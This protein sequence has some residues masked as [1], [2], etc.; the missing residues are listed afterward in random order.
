[1]TVAT[2]MSEPC[3]S[4][5]PTPTSASPCIFDG[6]DADII[7]RAPLHP[8]SNEFK[9][10][11]VHKLILSIASAVFRDMFSIPQPPH[12]ASSDATLDV[13]QLTEFANVLE[14]FLK[15]IYPV[16][17]PVIDNLRLL[18]DLFQLADKYVANGVT[19][20]LKQFLV[21]PSFLK[22]D[23]IG[24]Y[25]VASRSNLEEEVELAI[26][27]TYI[28]NIIPSVSAEHLQTMTTRTYHRLLEEH[29]NRRVKILDAFD[30]ALRIPA[31]WRLS[32][33]NAS[34]RCAA[35]LRTEIRLQISEKP[36]LNMEMLEACNNSANGLN[37][38][39]CADSCC[40]LKPG[41]SLA[42]M[43]RAMMKIQ[44]L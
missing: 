35:L 19:M 24:V 6:P 36:F 13:V 33:S 3:E 5:T 10:F 22:D 21:S 2:T 40:I 27:H 4:P 16:A 14:S 11:H 9:D 25:A 31:Q 17:P 38:R 8:G 20:K 41:A 30:E 12:P 32:N 23:P 37:P 43:R 44:G 26:S 7:L 29:A 18:D 15:L 1:M 28:I 34:C 39:P 42:L